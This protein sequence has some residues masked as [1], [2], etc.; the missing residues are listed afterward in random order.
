MN[1]ADTEATKNKIKED[2]EK[3]SQHAVGLFGEFKEFITSSS[4]VDLT[5]GVVLGASLGRVVTS[6][7]GDILMPLISLLFGGLEFDDLSVSIGGASI[8]YGSFITNVV[9][10]VI[11]AA[12]VFFFIKFF[13]HMRKKFVHNSEQKKQ[14]E[15]TELLIEIRDALLKGD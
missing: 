11:V 2:F 10:F 14:D 9:D 13:A 7:V 15:K 1:M 3:R 4:V 5:I 8:N 6:F 12:T